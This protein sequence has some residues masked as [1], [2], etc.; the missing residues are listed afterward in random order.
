[1]KVAYWTV[2]PT[3]TVEDRFKPEADL[4]LKDE[5]PETVPEMFKRMVES[6]MYLK[7]LVV[8]QPGEEIDD[9]L[10]LDEHLLDEVLIRIKRRDSGKE[11]AK[12]VIDQDHWKTWTYGEYYAESR[13]AAKG[14]IQVQVFYSGKASAY[15][16]LQCGLEVHHSVCILGFNTPHWHIANMAAIMAGY[17]TIV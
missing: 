15:F 12:P 5:A 2:D 3:K 13:L 10:S 11:H 6:N 14:F 17:A 16:L 4:S 7:A 8:P 9:K 1:M